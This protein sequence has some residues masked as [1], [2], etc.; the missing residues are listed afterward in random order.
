MLTVA[1][2]SVLYHARTHTNTAHGS[3][4]WPSGISVRRAGPDIERQRD[5]LD[6]GGEAEG[7]AGAKGQQPGPP[8]LRADRHADVDAD[9]RAVRGARGRVEQRLRQHV[10]DD[11]DDPWERAAP[12]VIIVT[13]A[14]ELQVDCRGLQHGRGDVGPHQVHEGA[15][16]PVGDGRG[17]RAGDRAVVGRGH[18]DGGR[19][20]QDERGEAEQQAHR[21]G[22]VG[23]VL[24]PPSRHGRWVDG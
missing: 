9:H 14:A 12:V 3:L 13:G 17:R 5:V 10:D 1:T 2:Y 21:L 15:V 24:L 22:A 11:Q 4:G 6:D 23:L 8:H 19:E 20:G 18:H 16:V 7:D